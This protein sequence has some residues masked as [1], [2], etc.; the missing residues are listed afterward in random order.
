[1]T[2]QRSQHAI[3]EGVSGVTEEGC[4]PGVLVCLVSGTGSVV[5]EVQGVF[6]VFFVLKVQYQRLHNFNGVI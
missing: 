2:H 6:S 3:C 5:R 1:V 4:H